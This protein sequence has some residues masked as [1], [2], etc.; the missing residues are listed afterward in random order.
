MEAK[1]KKIVEGNSCMFKRVA[2]HNSPIHDST[3]NPKA[4]EDWIRG[5]EK[6]FDALQCPK[7]WKVGFTVFYLKDKANLWWAK[8]ERGSTSLG[9]TRRGSRS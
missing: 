2:S 7:E 8:C 4:F 1:D 6:L 3:P 9:S 5:M